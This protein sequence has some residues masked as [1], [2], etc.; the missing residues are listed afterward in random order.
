[1]QTFLPFANYKKCA[2]V[3][4]DKRLG[5]QIVEAY[6]ILKALTIKDYGWKNHPAVKMWKG[7]RGSL[8]LYAFELYSE[9]R[10]RKN[11]EHKA[12]INMRAFIAGLEI[13]E[14]EY[15]VPHWLGSSALHNSHRSNLV[16][17][18]AEHYGKLWPEVEKNLAYFWPH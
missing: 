10:K 18:K 16:R 5:K 14:S 3:L 7:Y 13:D 6:Q 17:K 2:E 8:F 1:M 9:W 12:F 4:D 11:K 15:K